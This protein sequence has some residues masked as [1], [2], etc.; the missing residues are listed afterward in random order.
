MKLADS[1]IEE[2]S[3]T[4]PSVQLY[5]ELDEYDEVDESKDVCSGGSTCLKGLVQAIRC[6]TNLLERF[7]A[8]R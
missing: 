7:E 4:A 8:W 1:W 5:D 6:C 3:T 2:P